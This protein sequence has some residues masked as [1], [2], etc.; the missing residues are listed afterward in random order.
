VDDIH[1]LEKNTFNNYN[2]IMSDDNLYIDGPKDYDEQTDSFRFDLEN[3]IYRYID[4][5]DIN[6]ITIIGAL[7]EKVVELS[8]E[9]NVDFESDIELE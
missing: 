9:G 4:E 1:L 5:Y 6:T 2:N 3:L 8:N 7:Q